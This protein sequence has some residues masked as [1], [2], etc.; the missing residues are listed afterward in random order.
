V[1]FEPIISAGERPQTYAIDSAATGTGVSIN[2]NSNKYRVIL[3]KDNHIENTVHY[4]DWN[5]TPWRLVDM[6]HFCNKP[7]DTSNKLLRQ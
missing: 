2:I 5:M 3:L 6:C 1:G 4:Q 7:A